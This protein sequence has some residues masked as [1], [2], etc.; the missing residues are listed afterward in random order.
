MSIFDRQDNDGNNIYWEQAA[1]MRIVNDLNTFREI[2]RVVR[3]G[4]VSFFDL[5]PSTLR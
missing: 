4:S 1:A 5:F 3:Q 2:N